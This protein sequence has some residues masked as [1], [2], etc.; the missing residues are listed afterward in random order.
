MAS[1]INS[2]VREDGKLEIVVMNGSAKV[3]GFVIDPMDFSAS[4]RAQAALHGF[5]QKIVDAAALPV[6]PDTGKAATPEMKFHAMRDVVG[7]LSEGDWNRRATGDGTSGMGLLVAALVRVT[8]NDREAIEATVSKWSKE[9]Q[10]AM[11][12]TAAVAPIIAQIKAERAARRPGDDK[13]PVDTG[14]LLGAL[15]GS[16][17][18]MTPANDKAAP[19]AKKSA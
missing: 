15:M 3:G 2:T 11:R 18:P 12:A 4:I 17:V 14:K 5:K 6:D 1:V 8:G 16:A 9:E 19:K 10:A 7:Q 13:T